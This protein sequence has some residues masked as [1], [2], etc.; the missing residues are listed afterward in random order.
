MRATTR[1]AQE[2]I[3]VPAPAIPAPTYSSTSPPAGGDTFAFSLDGMNL[4]SSGGSG[5]W[6]R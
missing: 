2:E 6:G 4:S 5:L 1:P 3:V